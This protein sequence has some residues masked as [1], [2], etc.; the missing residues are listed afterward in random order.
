MLMH[1]LSKDGVL[2][3]G[4]ETPASM[5]LPDT[6]PTGSSAEIRRWFLSKSVALGRARAGAVPHL[7]ALPPILAPLLNRFGYH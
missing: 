7:A 2:D 1:R 4:A 3:W 5:P 6:P